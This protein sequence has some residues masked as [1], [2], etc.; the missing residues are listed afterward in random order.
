MLTCADAKGVKGT[1]TAAANASFTEA[2]DFLH[3]FSAP[4]N[5]T[6]IGNYKLYSFKIYRSD[7]LIHDLVPTL[8]AI[9]NPEFVDVVGDLKIA[10][11]GGFSAPGCAEGDPVVEYELARDVAALVEQV[12]PIVAGQRKFITIV[13]VSDTHKCKR[14]E[15]DD[16]PTNPVKDYWYH[17]E[18]GNPLL[19]S[20]EPSFRLLA[21]VVKQVAFDGIVHAGDF[22]TAITQKPFEDGDYLN[23]IRNVKAMVSAYLPGT[24]FF[25]VDGNHDRNYW[26]E[27]R[28]SGH[29]MSDAEWAAVLAEI[30]TD[31]SDNEAIVCTAGTGNSYALDF[32]RC[33]ANGGKNVRLVMTSI[34]DT[35]GGNDPAARVSEGL[36][37]GDPELMPSNTVVGVTAHDYSSALVSS[38]GPYLRKNPGAGFFGAITGHRHAAV[39][40]RIGGMRV[41]HVV[42]P[43]AFAAV[44]DI[45]SAAYRFSVFVFDTDENLVHEILVKGGEATVVS[46]PMFVSDPRN[47]ADHP[48]EAIVSDGS[49]YFTTDFVPNPQTDKIVV[50]LDL[51]RIPASEFVFAARTG[52]ADATTAYSLNLRTEG[53]RFDY[54]TSANQPVYGPLETYVKYTFTA[55][56]NVMTWDGGE[57]STAEKDE[58]FIRAGGPLR[59]FSA[60]GNNTYSSFRLYAFRIYRNGTL[61]HDLQ[62]YYTKTEGATL[63]DTVD[64]AE[65]I[66]LTHQGNGAFVAIEKLQLPHRARQLEWIQGDGVTSW[67]VT[68]F[69]PD[70]SRDKMEAAVTLTDV[71]AKQ[72]LFSAR[73][74]Y[75]V[76]AWALQMNGATK[77]RYDYNTAGTDVPRALSTD[78][79]YVF[80]ANTNELVWSHGAGITASGKVFSPAG[81]RLWL[82][83]ANGDG[84]GASNPSSAKLHSFRV[85]RDGELI[86]EFLPTRLPSGA[87]TLMD[88]AKCPTQIMIYGDFAAG[89]ALPPKGGFMLLV[90]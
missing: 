78:A 69:V 53:Y 18:K 61:I 46:H 17:D 71:S 86:H 25:A 7:V 65:P 90:K 54:K 56:N 67:F 35:N 45:T 88:W 41:D 73:T 48:L 27:G 40:E 50:T 72:F 24:P 3:I 23:E 77:I 59:I 32:K 6:S 79:Q 34:Y 28:T 75:N 38:V 37:F 57:T 15:G 21:K 8:N 80:T 44:G 1:V 66:A 33:L 5:T 55:E 19:T 30:N 81:G 43:N 16:D 4:G 10:M 2:G 26:N 76:D 84:G 83:A 89:P 31:V 29:S 64:G 51:L 11:N 12:N 62:P 9:G 87:V 49:C 14:V 52:S 82:L 60:V 58:K 63:V 36:V 13:C 70:P 22:S 42:V 47:V 20:P 39:T 68:D 85:W 74:S